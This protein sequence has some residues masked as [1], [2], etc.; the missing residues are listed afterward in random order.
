M[1]RRGTAFVYNPVRLQL[2]DMYGF[3]LASIPN[4]SF[5][6]DRNR[7]GRPDAWTIAGKGTFA[8]ARFVGEPSR[9]WRGHLFVRL[10]SRSR[11]S[12]T[13]PRIRV[14]PDTS[15]T[16]TGDFRTRGT[17]S[18]VAFRYFTCRGRPSA[19]RTNSAFPLP[20]TSGFKTSP[21]RLTTSTDACFVRIEIL[22]RHGL[23]EA[24]NL[25]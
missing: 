25:H 8:L 19:I 23:V 13:S 12:A 10:V 11:I 22:A 14:S 24:D 3:H 7:D 20:A 9:P 1:K 16:T 21:L 6:H 4:G 2:V 18:S 17:S 15:Y 5:E